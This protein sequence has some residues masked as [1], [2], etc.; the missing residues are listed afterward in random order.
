MKKKATFS[1]LDVTQTLNID[2]SGSF[3]SSGNI[4]SSGSITAVH[5]DYNDLFC[6]SFSCLSASFNYVELDEIWTDTCTITTL[7][8]IDS[9]TFAFIGSLNS[10]AQTQIDN[11][12]NVTWNVS[13]TLSNLS[14]TVSNVSASLSDLDYVVLSVCIM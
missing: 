7:N 3:V 12:S 14:H 13:E 9:N 10:N 2:D 4:F 6:K 8:D 5:G 1:V 11:V